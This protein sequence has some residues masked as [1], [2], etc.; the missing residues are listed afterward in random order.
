MKYCMVKCFSCCYISFIL[1]KYFKIIKVLKYWKPFFNYFRTVYKLF[2]H[3][4]NQH[5]RWK[6][7][8]KSISINYIYSFGSH[9]SVHRVPR[10]T[11]ITYMASH[12]YVPGNTWYLAVHMVC[13][14]S[15]YLQ[16]RIL[17][18]II[19]FRKCLQI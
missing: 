9:C 15:R 17:K 14:I 18:L 6:V 3:L 4:G 2:T 8:I 13:T 1:L 12:N 19:V 16:A 10:R 11:V 7:N 5:F